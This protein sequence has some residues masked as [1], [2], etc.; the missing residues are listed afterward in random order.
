MNS[1]GPRAKGTRCIQPAKSQSFIRVVSLRGFGSSRA[2]Q[3]FY[4]GLSQ[5]DDRVSKTRE[6]GSNPGRPAK[7][8]KDALRYAVGL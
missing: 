2:P 7:W 8:R 3:F 6:P 5:G 4:G 1:C